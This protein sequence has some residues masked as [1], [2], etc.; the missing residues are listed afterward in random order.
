MKYATVSECVWC[1]LVSG[2]EVMRE[3]WV[4]TLFHTILFDGNVWAK[5]GTRLCV[6]NLLRV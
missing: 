1:A 5:H 2:D 6:V 4:F 3:L